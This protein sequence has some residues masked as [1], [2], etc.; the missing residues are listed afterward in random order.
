MKLMLALALISL[1]LPALGQTAASDMPGKTA[2][3]VQFVQPKDW[4]VQSNGT[5]TVF[6]APESDLRVALV[7]VGAA[8]DARAAAAKAW[9][10]YKP[11][12]TPTPRLVTAAPAAEGWDD[13]A[14]IAYET[15]P[16][17][18]AVRSALALR[19]GQSWTVMIMD[20]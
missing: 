17:E 7:D 2:A 3:G 19:Q 15:A 20:G 14:S 1:P 8:A 11:T 18:R 9:S 10:L 6:A 12:V 16:N 4:T 13:R 5:V